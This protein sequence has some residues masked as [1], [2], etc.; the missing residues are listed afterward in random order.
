MGLS[1][2]I[3]I[4]PSWT[5]GSSPRAGFAATEEAHNNL[6]LKIKLCYFIEMN[7]R[8]PTPNFRTMEQAADV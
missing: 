5:V 7:Y 8:V 1:P 3:G 6:R 2:H 4:G